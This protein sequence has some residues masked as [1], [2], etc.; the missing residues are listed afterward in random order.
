MRI[1][2]PASAAL[3]ARRAEDER[4]LRELFWGDE[5]VRRRRTPVRSD[6]TLRYLAALALGSL[7]LVSLAAGIAV[8]LGATLLGLAV[9]VGVLRMVALADGTLSDSGHAYSRAAR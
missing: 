6:V 4:S 5:Y 9:V 2:E 8:V 1:E 3:R 7:C